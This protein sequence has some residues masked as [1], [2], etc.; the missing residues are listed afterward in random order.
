MLPRGEALREYDRHSLRDGWFCHEGQGP[1]SG[2]RSA[3]KFRSSAK[4]MRTS[5][6]QKRG[7]FDVAHDPN[8]PV[9][10]RHF[11]ARARK[12]AVRLGKN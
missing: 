10:Q 9:K 4:P 11:Y 3:P 5:Q 8:H 12:P 2:F 6:H 7:K 1:L